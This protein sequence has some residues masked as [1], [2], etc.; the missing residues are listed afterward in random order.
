MGMPALPH[1]K[2]VIIFDGI[3]VL[4]SFSARF[5]A[6]RDKAD[7]FRFATAQ[8]PL[9]QALY[10]HYGLDSSDFDT[11]LV[12][13]PDGVLHEKADAV[14]T[15]LTT[16]GGVWLAGGLIGFLPK[17]LRDWL[18]DRV[19]QNRYRLFGQTNL[20]SLAGNAVKDR[21]IDSFPP[22]AGQD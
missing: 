6:R 20:C 7:Q 3:C 18:Y 15:V 17:G 14:A 5:V 9:G 2:T 1:G 4:C 12:I 10:N 16:L 8:G 22:P 21:L 13:S 11:A 19:A